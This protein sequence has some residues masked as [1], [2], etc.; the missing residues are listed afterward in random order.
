MDGS[1]SR[2]PQLTTT[3]AWRIRD[4]DMFMN[5]YIYIYI[6]MYT[7]GGI[8]V[9]G[10]CFL[11]FWGGSCRKDSCF[12][13]GLDEGLLS[14]AYRIARMCTWHVGLVLYDS[15]GCVRHTTYSGHSGEVGYSGWL[16][17]WGTRS[18]GFKH[19]VKDAN[20]RLYKQISCSRKPKSCFGGECIGTP[21]S[22]TEARKT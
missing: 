20:Q 8:P 14:M 10:I 5:I 19:P 16:S 21:L 1:S 2:R 6:H 3:I 4:I 11:F 9:V 17:T 12:V 22:R 13:G 7:Y 18:M 15:P